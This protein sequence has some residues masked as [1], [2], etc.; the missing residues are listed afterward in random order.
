[1]AVIL[2]DN[3]TDQRGHVSSHQRW[4]AIV[5][6]GVMLGFAISVIVAYGY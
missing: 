2:G 1:M 3:E 6:M 4:A 5:C